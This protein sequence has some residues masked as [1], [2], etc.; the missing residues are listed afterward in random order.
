MANEKHWVATEFLVAKEET[1][2]NNHKTS[3]TAVLIVYSSFWC[4][5]RCTE[6]QLPIMETVKNSKLQQNMALFKTI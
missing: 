6:K 5:E 1:P 3:Q 4:N 2:V